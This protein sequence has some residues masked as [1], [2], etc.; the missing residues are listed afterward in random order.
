MEAKL[1]VA[2][3]DD[4]GYKKNV[5]TLLSRLLKVV[6]PE[7]NGTK[8]TRN[9]SKQLDGQPLDGKKGKGVCVEQPLFDLLESDDKEDED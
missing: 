3:A 4:C 2:E 5:L 1:C 9:N 8:S 7:V 6:V